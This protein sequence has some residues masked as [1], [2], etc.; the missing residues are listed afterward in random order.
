MRHY[1]GCIRFALIFGLLVAPTGCSS[2]MKSREEKEAADKKLEKLLVAPEPPDLVGEAT[3]PHGLTYL[4]IEGVAAVNGLPGTGGPVAP[5]V[6]R[7]DLIDEMKKNDVPDPQGFLE[8][9]ESALVRVQAIIPP[10]ARRGDPLD[11]R[12][13]SPTESDATDLHG[14]WLMDTRLRQQQRLGNAIRKSDVLAMGMGPVLVRADHE[15]ENDPALKLQGLV[16]GGGRVQQERKLGLVIRPEYQH[17]K[18]ATQ[19]AAAI[20]ARFFFFDGSTRTGIAKAVEDDFIEIQIHPRYRH[21]MHRLMA[22]A[23]MVSPSGESS[24]TQTI[25]TELGQ[26]LNEPTTAD[27][28]AMQLEAIGDGAIPTLVSALKNPNLEIRFYAA[29][30]LAYLDRKEAIEPL[31]QAARDEAAFRYPA[32]IALEG[33]DN[34]SALD[35]LAEL[36]NETSIE[37]RYGAMRSIRRRPDR[38]SVLRST[39]MSAGYRLYQLA[40]S[41]PPFIA[42]SLSEV[43]EIVCFGDVGAV[44]ID[45]FILGPSGLVIRP[46]EAGKNL[47]QISRFAPGAPDR[48]IEVPATVEG[49]LA[50]ISTV[51]AGYGESIAVLRTAKLNNQVTCGLALDPLPAAMRTY[52]RDKPP[53]LTDP[54]A[55]PPEDIAATEPAAEPKKNWWSWW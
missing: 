37:A 19:I 4:A 47:L 27:K 51:G 20:N 2:F 23:A 17:V 8:R 5:S 39:T 13:V 54:A 41:G 40:S 50:G 46:G 42:V 24:Q 33:M 49:L 55:L 31:K 43:P 1:F 30:S 16:L 3:V 26:R 18:V 44:K 28:A 35:A 6:Y 29:Q 9:P 7:D 11:I 12:I 25:L 32:L 34:R 53:E 52:Y 10:G 14:G 21:N 15:S 48:Q 45:D 22:V 38:E 36:M